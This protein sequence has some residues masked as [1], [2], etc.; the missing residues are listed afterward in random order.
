MKGKSFCFWFQQEQW[1]SGTGGCE[2]LWPPAVSVGGGIA[3][4]S[5]G[6]DR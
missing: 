4:G 1:P 5:S 2:L 3:G 6:D